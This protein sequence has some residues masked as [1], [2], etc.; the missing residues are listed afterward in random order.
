MNRGGPFVIEPARQAGEA[1]FVEQQ[2]EGVD[3][4]GMTGRR[5]FALDVVD[6]E[7]LFAQGDDEVTDAVALGRGARAGRAWGE[8]SGA[9]GGVM[10]ELV[11]EDTEGAGGIAKAFRH[12]RGRQAV[13]EV[14]P[15]GFV[16]ALGGG[17]GAEEEMSSLALR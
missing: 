8:E 5:E 3:A 11:A 15:E 12:L 4:N 13:D 10:A 1:F 7:V 2:G 9:A 17:F 14:G 16:L 6:G